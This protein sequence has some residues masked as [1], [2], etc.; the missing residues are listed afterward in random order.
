[1]TPEEKY[2]PLGPGHDAAFELVHN[3]HELG[4]YQ[5]EG[6]R[7]VRHGLVWRSGALAFLN[8]AEREHLARSGVRWDL[9]LR[10]ALEARDMPDPQVAGMAY[11]RVCGMLDSRGDEVDFSPEGMARILEAHRAA[12]GVEVAPVEP[13]DFADDPSRSPEA[14]AV[15]EELYVG[16]AFGSQAY[17]RLFDHLEVGEVPIL[18]HCT[19]GKDRT[20]V[21]A[22]LVLLALGA[23]EEDALFEYAL[24]N[25]YRESLIRET[26]GVGPEVDVEDVPEEVLMRFGVTERMGSEVLDAIKGRYGSY[27]AYFQAEYGLDGARL[28]AL[29]DRCTE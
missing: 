3:V 2:G 28:A 17:Q 29:R 25:A 22:M 12:R 7:T 14:M 6:G 13:I 23:S 24:T 15:M 8:A 20:G 5:V 27:E 10:S 19:S 18:F 4:G 26:T 11:E 9:D 1:M 21:A 16:M